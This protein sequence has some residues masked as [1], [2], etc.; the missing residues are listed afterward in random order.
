MKEKEDVTLNK[1]RF[2]SPEFKELWDKIKYKTVYQVD[3]SSEELIEKCLVEIEKTLTKTQRRISQLNAL[4]G[5]KQGGIVAK[6]TGSGREYSLNKVELEKLPDVVTNLQNATDLTRRT[7]IDILI[8]SNTL[9]AFE[10]NPQIYMQEM[11]DIINSVKEN[12]IVDGIKY[13]K[14]RNK[15]Y[16]AQ[17][18]F[19]DEEISGYLN[20]NLLTSE[21]GVYDYVVYDSTVEREFAEKLETNKDVLVYVKLPSWFKIPTPLGSYNP[22]WAILINDAGKEKFYFV[23]ET[24]STLRRAGYRTA[25]EKKIDCGIEHFKAVGEDVKYIVATTFD[26]VLN[27]VNS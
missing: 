17:E 8:R 22:D 11:A 19:E 15:S 2:L 4:V 5:I 20:D 12:F 16:Y 18:L 24:K 26:D 25:E 13:S 1:E 3:F 21:K 10:L 23:T 27:K 9:D 14:A 6:E 7:I